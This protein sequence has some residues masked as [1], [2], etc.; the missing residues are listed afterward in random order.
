MPRTPRTRPLPPPDAP[1]GSFD[2]PA[3]D[4]PADGPVMIVASDERR[5]RTLEVTMRLGGLTPIMR[6]SLAEARRKTADGP[7]P[8]AII[9]DLDN[10]STQQEMRAAWRLQ[11]KLGVPVI[12]IL[13]EALAGQAQEFRRSGL[14]VVARPHP[15]SALFTALRGSSA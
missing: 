9:V 13:P 15:P 2:Q 8:G 7:P 6:R 1:L 3:P 11:D 10:D 12:V 14:R 5:S 4:G